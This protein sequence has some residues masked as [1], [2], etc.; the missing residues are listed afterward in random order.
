MS[1]QTQA[2][3]ALQR[4]V[5]EHQASSLLQL[6]AD[7]L[8]QM[9]ITGALSGGDRINE[10]SL[11]ARL[12]V[13]R[14]PVREALRQLEYGKLVEFR[15]NRGMFVREVS[16]TEAAQLYDIRASLFGLAGRLAAEQV[17]PDQVRELRAK[18]DRLQAAVP[19]VDDY[20]PRNVDLHRTLVALSGNPRLVNL[21]DDVSKELHLFRRHG[22]ETDAARHVSNDQHAAILDT[23]AAGDTAATAH[24][25]EAHILSGKDRML[26]AVHG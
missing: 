3:S 17:T 5:A 11:A 6:I 20:Y 9:I 26:A 24:L 23:L 25:M 22:L 12:G 4:R 1:E 18:V 19:T 10:S 14:G 21:Y 13:S 2:I 7:E 15:T 8:E 16:V